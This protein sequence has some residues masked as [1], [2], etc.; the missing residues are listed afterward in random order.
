LLDT[1]PQFQARGYFETPDHPVVG[2]M[3]LPSLPFRYASVDRWLRTAAPTLGQHNEAVLCGI[4][5]LSLD[6]LHGLEDDGV[7]GT[8]PGGL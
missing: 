8:R 4:L 2:P 6:E 1:N 5:G 7:I 3:P